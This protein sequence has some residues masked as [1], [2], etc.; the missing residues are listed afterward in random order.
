MKEEFRPHCCLPG[1]WAG[2]PLVARPPNARLLWGGGRGLRNQSELR[3]PSAAL[4]CINTASP[5]ASGWRPRR[6]FNSAQYGDGIRARDKPLSP[7]LSVSSSQLP[8]PRS[9]ALTALAA[10]A[11]GY[12]GEVGD[13]R[14]S[15]VDGRWG[16]E[17]TQALRWGFVTHQCCHLVFVGYPPRA[18]VSSF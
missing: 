3:A 10:M 17:R 15:S 5:Q 12:V 4:I 6:Q 14:G 11:G 16:A 18:W 7:P 9:G 2:A 8:G 13:P 1:R